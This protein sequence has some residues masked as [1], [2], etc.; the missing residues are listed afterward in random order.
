VAKEGRTCVSIVNLITGFL[1]DALL[2]WFSSPW[3]A[4]AAAALAT[5]LVMLLVVR[6]TSSPAAVGRARNRLTARVLEL[7]LFR[8]DAFVSFTAGGRIL[9]ANLAYLRTLLRP[10]ALS[11]AP[12]LLILAQLACW[13]DARPLRVG[14]AA[15]IE[16][17]LRDGLTVTDRAVLLS[18]AE[19]VRVETDGMRVP[20]LAEI[21]WRLRGARPGI[22]RV[23]IHCGDEAPVRKDVVVGDDF[24]KVSRRRSQVGLWEQLLYP[25]EPTIDAAQ[26][27]VQIDVRYPARQMY[28]G[29]WEIHWLVAF[30]ALTIL[31]ALVLKRPLHVQ[32]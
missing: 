13:F 15:L 5:S 20:R 27:I 28:L 12:C 24:Q 22:D 4:L 1:G 11:L 18:G 8:H 2:R 29:N 32:I 3:P 31:F 25:C 23:E 6:W 19:A 21:D 30:L 7:V 17:K 9:A 10:V 16:V 26:S 14:E